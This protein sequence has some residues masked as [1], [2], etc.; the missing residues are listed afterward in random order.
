MYL[1]V[2]ANQLCRQALFHDGK[3]LRE[4]PYALLRARGSPSTW[5]QQGIIP[6]MPRP[7]PG[8][9]RAAIA[10]EDPGTTL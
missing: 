8:W 6:F 3:D 4:E 1:Y 2:T 7:P 9:R 10:V 5:P